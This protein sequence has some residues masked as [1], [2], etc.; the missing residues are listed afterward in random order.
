MTKNSF[1]NVKYWVFDLDNTL[2]PKSANLFA[3]IEVKMTSFVM[4]QLNVDFKEA[5]FLRDYYWKKYGTTLA[6]M[7]REHD[8]DPQPYLVDVHDI[9][10][11][12]LDVDPRLVKAIKNL[13]GEKI[14]YTNGSK[15]HANRVLKARGLTECFHKIYGV[16]D[17]N[18]LPKP[19]KKAYQ[20]IIELSGINPQ[21][22]AMFEDEYKN[23]DVPHD[24]GMRTVYLTEKNYI[25]ERHFITDNLTEF[26]SKL[27]NNKNGN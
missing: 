18:Y 6:G 27:T 11:T 4:Q 25:D 7:M 1:N 13:S 19:E 23:L 10:L 12:S 3:E 9:S 5:N 20:K 15:F 2:Y 14:V 17:A 22:S 8:I 21:Y 16:E 26:L 24:L